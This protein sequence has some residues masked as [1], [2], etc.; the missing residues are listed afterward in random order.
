[1]AESKNTKTIEEKLADLERQVEEIRKCRGGMLSS[2]DFREYV[3]T[4][5]NTEE[6]VEIKEL[7]E[8]RQWEKLE[9]DKASGFIIDP[10]DELNL[11]P[12]SYDLSIGDEVYSCRTES[13]SSFV[14][15]DENHRDQ[16][17]LM[18]PGE[19][20]IIRT[21]EYIALPPCYSAT[22]WPRFD[23]VR[24]G[25]F[26]SM[27]KIDPTWYGQL[28]VALTNV[29]P[30]GYPIWKGKRFAT[31]IIYELRSKTDINLF[32]KGQ[33]LKIEPSES[34]QERTIPTD[35]E[36][37]VNEEIK[38]SNLKGNCEV[39]K[40]QLIIRTVLDRGEIESLRKMH[41]SEDWHHAIERAV[42]T[43]SCDALGLPALDLLLERPTAGE[44]P[45]GPKRLTREDVANLKTEG[46]QRSLVK[47]AIERGSPFE[48][49]ATIPTL[50]EGYVRQQVE[51]EL[52]KE[53]GRLL[54]RIIALTVSILGFISLI[55]AIIALIA[56]YL[57][58]EFPA[59]VD[60]SGTLIVAMIVLGVTLVVV[61]IYIFSL[62]RTPKGIDK[63]RGEV[64]EINNELT[65]RLNDFDGR[66]QD[67]TTKLWE[68]IEN[69]K[70]RI[71][72]AKG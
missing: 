22:I 32:R 63:I 18:Q 72:E 46:L 34:A 17:H 60:W 36:N 59:Q 6:Y 61:L 64:K 15:G 66:V 40:G 71:K 3:I 47:A 48:L 42:R 39:K 43:K 55:V 20:V 27:V 70:S 41:R 8:S 10:Y 21:K 68:E 5:D 28:G 24:E 7:F 25:I 65:K 16:W 26:Q 38:K 54:P 51:V 19:T 45:K 2:A 4:R 44:E 62:L 12:Y 50:I 57:Q 29:S 11:T 31:L 23:F 49:V 52:S 9:D 69:I 56:R 67:K 53:I 30:A 58:W 35:V 33:T 37:K 1:M 13:R 14:I